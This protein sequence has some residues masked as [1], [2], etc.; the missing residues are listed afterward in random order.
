MDGRTPGRACFLAVWRTSILSASVSLSSWF[1]TVPGISYSRQC[2]HLTTSPSKSCGV[3]FCA[4]APQTLHCMATTSVTAVTDLVW[5]PVQLALILVLAS[6]ALK[7]HEHPP[8][9]F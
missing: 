4:G 3:M 9:L 2:A 7:L 6:A 8:Q 5:F 1:N